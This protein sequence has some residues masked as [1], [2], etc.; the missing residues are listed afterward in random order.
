MIKRFNPED[1]PDLDRIIND[2]ESTLNCPKFQQHHNSIE[3]DSWE[4]IKVK[5]PHNRS[6]AEA[7][8][9]FCTPNFYE[10]GRF[11]RIIVVNTTNCN[12]AQFNDGEI[13]AIIFHELGHLLNEPELIQEPSFLYCY[14]NGI[15]YDKKLHDKIV[16]MNT[17]NMEVYADSYANQHGY[18]EELISTFLK[19][20]MHFDQKIGYL[21]E[22][23]QN[24]N[25]KEF[26]KGNV[27]ENKAT[28]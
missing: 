1:Y 15:L 8:F 22:R 9:G 13:S 2:I 10:F 17:M 18:G 16:D 24:I 20:N 14:T 28:L 27:M 6:I 12:L 4:N 25:S 26:F 11:A 3:I 21:D 19:Q 7:G 5:M 23:V